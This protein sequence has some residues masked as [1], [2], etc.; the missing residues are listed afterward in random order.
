MRRHGFLAATVVVMLGTATGAAAQDTPEREARRL[1]ASR[2][3]LESLLAHVDQPG[4]AV[5][6]VVQRRL[7]DGDFQ[8]GEGV[9]LVVE[10][11]PLLSDTFVVG[12]ARELTLPMAGA[13]SLRGV[14]HSEIESYLTGRLAEVVRDPVVHARGLLRVSVT[15]AVARPGFHL[16]AADS[17]LSDAVNAAGGLTPDAK[18]GDLRVERD[19]R[20]FLAGGNI[21]QALSAG[22][23]LD[24]AGVRSGDQFV[25]PGRRG[26]GT[27]D[28]LRFFA[29]LLSIPATAYTLTRIF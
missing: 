26:G 14:L 29:L 23:T 9:L 6:L 3:T 7:T 1:S 27:Y 8:P 10:G 4:S 19:G 22:R 5:A 28:Q 20:R 11:E 13:V 18:L 15:G 17:P 24:Q 21:R 25:V 2:D 12:P 16:V